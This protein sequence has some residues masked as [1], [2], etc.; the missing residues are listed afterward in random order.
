MT[1][2]VKPNISE[3]LDS[4][5]DLPMEIDVSSNLSTYTQSIDISEHPDI[6]EHDNSI[7]KICH[8]SFGYS[9]RSPD[10]S[11]PDHE[12]SQKLLN[13]GN[14][15]HSN[16][17]VEPSFREKL[18]D[19]AV[20]HRNHLT[21]ETIEDLL[22][23]LREENIPDLPKS[24]TTLLQT[25]SNTNIKPMNSLKNTTGFYMYLGIEQGLKDIITDEYSENCIRLLFNID[26]LPLFNDHIAILQANHL[27]HIKEKTDAINS[28]HIAK[29]SED[30]DSSNKTYKREKI[31]LSKL[32]S[33]IL[34]EQPN[35][36]NIEKRVPEKNSIIAKEAATKSDIDYAVKSIIC[37]IIVY[38]TFVSF[39]E[40]LKTYIEL[41]KKLKLYMVY[42]IKKTTKVIIT[43][44]VQL[45]YTAFGRETNGVR[46]LNF[47]VTETYK[48]SFEVVSTKLT[49][50][51]NKEI[52]S[53]L[54]RWFSGAKNRYG[55][56][57]ERLDNKRSSETREHI[58]FDYY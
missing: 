43:K 48:Y 2:D 17:L 44:D 29:S 26:G 10:D 28:R 23:I 56:K 27:A 3:S 40:Q 36:D 22:G 38:R 46:K 14:D 15:D 8:S 53:Q 39:D 58:T 11:L 34:D 24:A 57:R 30:T 25:K 4:S 37:R 35:T 1:S 32:Q 16:I 20:K 19:W 31:N 52:S 6:H 51:D 54:S 55:R 41:L 47:S 42:N 45:L 21:V 33:S 49:N 9:D 5:N 50:V 12:F 13:L 7:L 18:Q